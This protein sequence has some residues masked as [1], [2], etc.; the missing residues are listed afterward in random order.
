MSLIHTPT[1][2]ESRRLF[3]ESLILK[4]AEATHHAAS[5]M[6]SANDS[7]WAVEPEQLVADLNADLGTS[8]ATMS[9]NEAQAESLN[10]SL[11][12]ID[13]PQFSNRAPTQIGNP[14][15]TFDGTEFVYTPPSE[16]EPEP[17]P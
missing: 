7:Y 12:L 3:R 13:L 6:A 15:I 1:A 4:V 17:E 10:A 8:I 5:V 2:A 9:A 16:P 11:V 14:L